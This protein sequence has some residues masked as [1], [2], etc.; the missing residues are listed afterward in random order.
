M[1]EPGPDDAQ[2]RA[3]LTLALRTPDHGKLAPW[4][5]IIVAGEQRPALAALLKRAYIAEIPAAADMDLK[6]LD[7]FAFQAPRLIVVLS[8]P[9]REAKIPVSE[10]QLSA[11]A[12]GMNLLHAAHAYGFVGSWLTGWAAYNRDVA[13]AF[14]AAEGD[15]IAGYFFIGT[16]AKDLQERPRP[17]YDDVVTD[18][19][20]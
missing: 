13:A 5:I 9:R 11:G 8:T 17:D 19:D 10:Q 1:I 20:I 7:E 2:L 15:I 16:P 4:R 14:G 6:P 12:L 18:W 3:I